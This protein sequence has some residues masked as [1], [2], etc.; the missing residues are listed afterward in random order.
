MYVVDGDCG[1]RGG[2]GLGGNGGFGFWM[3]GV[4][5]FVSFARAEPEQCCELL[6]RSES[7]VRLKMNER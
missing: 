3:L 6:E 4:R 7:S 5:L 2:F 1:Y